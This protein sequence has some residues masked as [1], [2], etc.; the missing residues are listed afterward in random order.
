MALRPLGN[1]D[2]TMRQQSCPSSTDPQRV[3]SA[4]S[5]AGRGEEAAVF[6][7]QYPNRQNP[8]VHLVVTSPCQVTSFRR[9]IAASR[10]TEDESC[11][12]ISSARGRSRAK[13][14][15]PEGNPTLHMRLAPVCSNFA[16]HW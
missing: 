12:R 7:P 6:S 11:S 9:L 3:F 1:D 8:K 5:F 13:A 15:S 16:I 14:F 10:M 2:G 4:L